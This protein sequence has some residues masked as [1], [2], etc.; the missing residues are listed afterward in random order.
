[1]KLK[2]NGT[3][4]ITAANYEARFSSHIHCFSGD[5]MFSLPHG[6]VR[7]SDQRAE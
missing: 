3:G 7:P 5:I 1:M 6:P 2:L 4:T